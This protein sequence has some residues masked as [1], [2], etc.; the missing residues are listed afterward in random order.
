MGNLI[1]KLQ[2]P[3]ARWARSAD[4]SARGGRVE[5]PYSRS[6]TAVAFH[7]TF[8]EPQSAAQS[9]PQPISIRGRA[10]LV[11]RSNP[12]F[13]SLDQ[14]I[15]SRSRS[16]TVLSVSVHIAIVTFILWVALA[17]HTPVVDSSLA[18]VAP[19]QFTL[20]DPPPPPVLQVAKVRGGGGGGG[21]H[22]LIAPT[23][24]SLPK[25][26]ARIPV[27]PLEPP[28]IETPKLLVQPAV[29][30]R[31][32]ETQM[33]KLGVPQTQQVAMAS[34]GG[35]SANGFGFGLG[36]GVGSGHGTGQGPG[37][38]RGYGGGIM[39]VGGGVSA[40]EVI[41]SVQPQFTAEARS[42]NFQGVVAVQLIV[43][44]Q[45]FPQDVSVVRHLGMGLDEE[46]ITAVK[47][48]RFRPAQY[49][50]RSVSVKMVID[51]D[52]RLD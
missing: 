9:G 8:E 14:R 28:K 18:A 31:M 32:P 22:Q 42:Q 30:I 35:G 11:T 12:M 21:A 3:A 4:A 24:G 7:D 19:I 1:I 20:Y 25:I 40:P 5:Y 37:S 44:S 10:A 15:N 50:G 41:H 36:A 39:S 26:V 17:I 13:L 38:D 27:I 23:R 45:G 47:Q 16:T 29:A 51:V 34:Q 6:S 49:E 48:Y 52:F 43:D 2:G 46:A 33:P